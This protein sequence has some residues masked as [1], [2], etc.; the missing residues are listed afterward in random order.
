MLIFAWVDTPS[1]RKSIFEWL[2]P[3]ENYEYSYTCI[4]RTAPML[5]FAWLIL[6]VSKD[7]RCVPWLDTHVR[8]LSD[9]HLRIDKEDSNHRLV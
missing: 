3:E 4:V 7:R 2:L 9:R 5:I 8:T 6:S 1:T